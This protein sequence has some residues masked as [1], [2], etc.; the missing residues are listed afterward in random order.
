MRDKAHPPGAGKDSFSIVDT[1]RL[2]QLLPLSR[3]RVLLDLGC[4]RGTYSLALAGATS[5]RILAIDLWWKGLEELAKALAERKLP[6]VYPILA[7]IGQGIPAKGA[8]VDLC[9]MVNVFH[10]MVIQKKE[11]KA[12]EEVSRVLKPLGT[13]AIIEFKLLPGPPGPPIH[14][15]IGPEELKDK[16]E[17]HGF[18]KEKVTS[19][20]R[21]SYLAMFHRQPR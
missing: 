17:P 19:I 3:C 21:Y 14:I 13:L 5:S 15:R 11:S 2:F 8:A 7:D 6:R 4:G 10:E 16:V 18:K 9:L 20:G 1:E 12:L